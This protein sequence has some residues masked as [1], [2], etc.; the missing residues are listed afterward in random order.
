MLINFVGALTV[1][2]G[3]ND[4][5]QLGYEDTTQCGDGANEMGDNLPTVNLGT[6]FDVA[7]FALPRHSTCALSTSDSGG[8]IKCFGRNNYGQLGHGDTTNRGNTVDSMGDA[9]SVVDIG[10]GWAGTGLHLDTSSNGVGYHVCVFEDSN[11]FLL[12]C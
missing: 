10:S 1:Y 11:E 8:K 4:Y 5:G 7:D 6:D 2:Q 9:L 12:K 3:D